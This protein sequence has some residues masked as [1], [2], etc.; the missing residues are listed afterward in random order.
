MTTIYIPQRIDTA[1]QAEALPRGTVAT[2]GHCESF[3]PFAAIRTGDVPDWYMTTAPDT[4]ADNAEMVGWTALVPVEIFEGPG[5]HGRSWYINAP[6][7][8]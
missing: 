7:L 3:G 4:W 8:D 1:E 5:G 2:S 6:G